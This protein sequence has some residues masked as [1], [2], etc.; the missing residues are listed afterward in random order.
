[1]DADV[2]EE[3]ESKY[4]RLLRFRRQKQTLSKEIKIQSG[5]GHIIRRRKGQKEKRIPVPTM[6]P[7][8]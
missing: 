8:E 5:T 4:R 2:A 6:H 1:M 7:S 3:I